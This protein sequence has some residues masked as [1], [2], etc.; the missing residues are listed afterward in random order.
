MALLGCPMEHTVPR[1]TDSPIPPR[2]LTL[3]P[4]ARSV[5]SL[6][7]TYTKEGRIAQG[8]EVAG[9]LLYQEGKPVLVRG[10][11][12]FVSFVGNL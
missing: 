10:L 9:G 11:N 3:E 6:L 12:V 4:E 7:I 8:F 2:I 5:E 1:E